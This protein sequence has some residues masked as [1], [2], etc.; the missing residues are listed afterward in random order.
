MNNIF[1]KTT[2]PIFLLIGAALFSRK[3]GFL[4]SGDERVFSAYL[5]YFALPALF[6]IN[7]AEKE[8]TEQTLIFFLAG[9]IPIFIA[10]VVHI[11]LYLIFRFSRDTLYL[12]IL[13]TVFGSLALFG[14]PFISFAFPEKGEPLATLA[15]AL[16]SIV[17][18]AISIIT[19]ELYRLDQ[20]SIVRGLKT[21]A[22]RFSKNPLI[23]SIFSGILVSVV[24]IHIP[25][26][27]SRPLHM[28]GGTTSTV[29][30]FMLGVFFYGRKYTNIGTA[31][32]LTMLRMVFLPAIA[33]LT[34]T[35]FDLSGLE[36]PTLILMHGMP[37]AISMMVLSQRYNFFKET[38]A[39]LILVS[40]LGAGLY[41]NLWLFLLNQYN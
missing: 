7:L 17:S 6:F 14:I 28:L 20:S 37:V 18:V 33:L 32:K 19:L 30:V 29:A 12:L 4:K 2:V 1:I 8:L 25:S 3:M 40:S 16:I 22:K 21:V 11:F 15:A 35:F 41:L 9:I 27:L 13:S 24:S 23:L 39:S 38:I 5:Y 26:F 36:R 31:L 10:L 34:T